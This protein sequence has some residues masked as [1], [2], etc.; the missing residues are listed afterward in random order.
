MLYLHMKSIFR[1]TGKYMLNIVCLFLIH[2]TIIVWISIR[3]CVYETGD[4][5]NNNDMMVAF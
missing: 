1:T 2:F 3:Q 5:K 4:K